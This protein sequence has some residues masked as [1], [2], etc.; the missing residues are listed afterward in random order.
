M[1]GYVLKD[2]ATEAVLDALHT[3]MRGGTW[4]SRPVLEKPARLERAGP[5]GEPN[6]TAREWEILELMARS[7]DN[8][9]IVM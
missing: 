3:V 2:E 5:A 6:L 1:A 4:F 9:C 8:L 7:W